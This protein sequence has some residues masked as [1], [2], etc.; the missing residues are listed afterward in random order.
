MTYHSSRKTLEQNALVFHDV[1]SR[2]KSWG[3]RGILSG[4]L[5]GFALGVAFV[6]I[7]HNASVLTFGIIGT[8]IV[9][10][11][12]GA[13]IAGTFAACAA[14]LYAKGASLSGG[15]ELDQMPPSYARG[16]TG[17]RDRELLLSEWPTSATYPN[18][19]ALLPTSPGET[20]TIEQ[21]LRSAEQW[22]ST[23]DAWENGNTGTLTRMPA[24][25]RHPTEKTMSHECSKSPDSAHDS[26]TV[27]MALHGITCIPVDNFYYREFHYTNLNDAIAQ[28][29]RNKARLAPPNAW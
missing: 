13:V 7:P 3:R 21:T 20:G 6:A 9:A 22:L 10:T 29:M 19:V 2:V 24:A 23:I 26:Q 14:A 16:A 5:A 28:S 11:F 12:E 4:G 27:E 15:A 1:S 25:A 17:R 18:W 8:L